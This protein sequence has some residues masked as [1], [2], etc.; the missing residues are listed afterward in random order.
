MSTTPKAYSLIRFSRPGQIKIDSLRRKLEESRNYA[1]AK[2]FNLDESLTIEDEGLNTFSG[3]HKAKVALGSFL[4]A[5]KN[6]YV[7][8]GSLLIIESL[9]IL[10]RE[11]MMTVLNLFNSIIAKGVSIVTLDDG[12]EYNPDTINTNVVY[13]S[14]KIIGKEQSQN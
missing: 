8:S 5:V 14:R 1:Q 4:E 11:E 3:E 10:S 13:I 7:A 2:G 9:D 6:G 12:Y